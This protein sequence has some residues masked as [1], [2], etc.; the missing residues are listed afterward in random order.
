MQDLANKLN[1]MKEGSAPRVLGNS[2]GRY[3]E[4]SHRIRTQEIYK[5]PGGMETVC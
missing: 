1:L 4:S 3:Q 2:Q 5:A